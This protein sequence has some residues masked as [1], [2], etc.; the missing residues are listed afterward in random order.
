MRRKEHGQRDEGRRRSDRKDIRQKNRIKA[1]ADGL[2]GRLGN[3]YPVSR[4]DDRIQ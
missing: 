4:W 3:L 1:G 2:E